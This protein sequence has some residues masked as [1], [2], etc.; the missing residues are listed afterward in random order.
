MNYIYKN[1][2]AE[3]R[4]GSNNWARVK[5]ERMKS[6]DPLLRTR[7]FDSDHLQYERETPNMEWK[8]VNS[9]KA[10]M[11]EPELTP[12]INEVGGGTNLQWNQVH[13]MKYKSQSKNRVEPEEP[14]CRSRH[15]WKGRSSHIKCSVS[16][17]CQ[18]LKICLNA[19]HLHLRGNNNQQIFC[20]EMSS[21]V[22]AV[23]ANMVMED[24]ETLAVNTFISASML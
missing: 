9:D 13:V 4:S 12:L 18:G 7:L 1:L 15:A 6:R 23:I 20:T 5:R 16:D 11:K 10:Q 21:P 24:G 22:S 14:E 8:C 2:I 17:I 3:G 19:T